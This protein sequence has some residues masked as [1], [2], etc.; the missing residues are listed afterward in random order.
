MILKNDTTMKRKDYMTPT[1]QVVEVRQQACLMELSA[2]RQSYGTA[3]S[4]VTEGLDENGIWN[5]N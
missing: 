3:N 5:W 4:D 1:T 2:G